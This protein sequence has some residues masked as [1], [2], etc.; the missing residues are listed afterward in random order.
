MNQ[1]ARF[2]YLLPSLSTFALLACTSP[3]PEGPAGIVLGITSDLKAGT[4]VG[5]LHI[6]G[7]V[8]GAEKYLIDIKG[9]G[10]A[11]PHETT[12]IGLDPGDTLEMKVEAYPPGLSDVPLLVRL[13]S[14]EAVANEIHLLKV[15]LDA[16]CQQLP[17]SSAPVCDAPQTCVQGTC[18]D[19]HVPPEKTPIYDEDW[20]TSTVDTCKPAGAGDPAVTVGEGQADY[21]PLAQGAVVQVEAGP[22]GGHHVWVAVRMKNLTQSGS[23]TSVTG[24]LPELGYDVGPFNVIFTFDPDEGG[25][26]KLYGLRFQLDTE[27]P[28]EEM[29]G[30][31][32]EI[33]VS[34]KDKDGDVGTGSQT[35]KLS[36]DIL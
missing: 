11:F 21:L 20:A 14:T 13:A 3:P 23:V 34:V 32:L 35:V 15:N 12:P 7:T 31:T 16:S 1:S 4:E 28:I 5:R 30:K 25:Y 10:L 18:R 6:E 9:D 33:S 2:F 27:H 17:G 26:C 24:H 22:Q 19:S 8:D 29:L 36:N